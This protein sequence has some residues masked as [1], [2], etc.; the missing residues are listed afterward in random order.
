LKKDAREDERIATM[1]GD[2]NPGRR[3]KIQGRKTRHD[4]GSRSYH[5]S[6]LTN[7]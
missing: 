2:S 1:T 3:K 6:L 7:G 4:G 5:F